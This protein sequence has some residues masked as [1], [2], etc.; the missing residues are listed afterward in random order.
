MSSLKGPSMGIMVKLHGR[1]DALVID[2]DQITYAEG[3]NV[4]EILNE[5]EEIV[6][7][8]RDW[9]YAIVQEPDEGYRRPVAGE[10]DDLDDEDFDEDEDLEDDE[11]ED[12]DLEEG[13]D[14]GEVAVTQEPS[15]AE[16]EAI[17]RAREAVARAIAERNGEP[18]PFTLEQ[19]DANARRDS[20]V[21]P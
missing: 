11:E 7:A 4:L 18:A 8:F 6:G 19:F 1:D 13:D 14:L 20:Q 9:Q 21:E 5:D 16:E 12:E 15:L 17:Q 10:D 2:G 3:G